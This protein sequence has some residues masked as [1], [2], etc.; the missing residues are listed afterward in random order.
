M[1]SKFWSSYF[2]G[3]IAIMKYYLAPDSALHSAPYISSIFE[4]IKRIV[5]QYH[6]K[7]LLTTKM[8]LHVTAYTPPSFQ[9]KVRV[10]NRRCFQNHPLFTKFLL[11]FTVDQVCYIS[12][13][14]QPP[15]NLAKRQYFYTRNFISLHHFGKNWRSP[16]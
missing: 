2:Q 1:I 16:S 9:I 8:F 7:Q 4:N 12:Y 14:Y 10:L 11:V 6:S 3:Q 13:K 15:N 5:Y